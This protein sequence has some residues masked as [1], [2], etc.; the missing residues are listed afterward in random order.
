MIYQ[1]ELHYYKYNF[2][3]EYA[4]IKFAIVA[5]KTAEQPEEVTLRVIT[6]EGDRDDR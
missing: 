6:E 1:V 2:A 3:D 5:A 4:A